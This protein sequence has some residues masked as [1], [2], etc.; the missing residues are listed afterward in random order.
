MTFTQIEKDRLTEILFFL[1]F[2]NQDEEHLANIDF[3]NTIS[4]LCKVYNVDSAQVSRAARIL[5]A[6]ENRPSEFETWYLL[7]KLGVTVRPLRKISGIYWQ[8]QKHFAET[9]EKYGPP[10]LKRR[11]SDAAMKQNVHAFLIALVDMFGTLSAIEGKFLNAF[12]DL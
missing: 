1:Y 3:W 12:F 11:I 4:S 6:D 8:K 5:F 7:D 9:V 2:D 10:T